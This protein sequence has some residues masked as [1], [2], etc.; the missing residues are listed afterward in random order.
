M[1]I[2]YPVNLVVFPSS[3]HKPRKTDIVLFQNLK[4]RGVAFIQDEL[5]E[6]KGERR[7]NDSRETKRITS[8]T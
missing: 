2:L 4:R 8:N 3:M 1:Q 5:Q 6:K 7:K